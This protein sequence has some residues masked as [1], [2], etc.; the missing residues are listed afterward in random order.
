[1]TAPYILGIDQGTTSTTAQ[2][3][4]FS[5]P[6]R[7]LSISKISVDHPQVYPQA[8]WVS[9]RLGDIWDGV[10]RSVQLT[11]AAANAQDSRF[12]PEKI[13]AIGLTNQRETLCTFERG[14]GR[15]LYDTIVWQCKRSLD[16]CQELRAAQ[17][18]ET[19]RRKTGLLLDPYFTASKMTW[20]LR[21]EP[22]V[23]RMID[24][25][26]ALWGTIDTW[27]LY[28][29]TAGASYATEGSNASR[30]LLHNI[31][32]G[33][34]DD[35]LLSIFGVPHRDCLPEIRDSAGVFG[36][37]N[38]LSFL[39]DGIPIAGIL[40]DQ[41]AALAGQT[42]FLP[43]DAKCTYGTGAFI[44]INS[45]AQYVPPPEGLLATVAWTLQGQRTYA[46]EG[47]TF[48]AGAAVQ[49]IREQ[50][51]L[52][53]D[54]AELDRFSAEAIGSPDIYFVP[55]LSGLGS[56]H[57]VPHARGAIL[58]MTRG[59]TRAELA[60]AALEGIAFSVAELMDVMGKALPVKTTILKV[61][62]GAA[63]NDTLMRIQA[64]LA[65][66]TIDRPQNLETTSAGAALF[67]AHGIGLY[68]SL[69]RMAQARQ[70]DVMIPPGSGM[71]SSVPIQRHKDGWQRAVAAVKTFAGQP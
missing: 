46:L 3:F 51:G 27:L 66:V 20:L 71:S 64:D 5:Q 23:R 30:T 12:K 34:Y 28:R 37:T 10:T 1:M 11:L 22:D 36:Y 4:D 26:Q 38:G 24:A 41:Q 69:S 45:G 50:L 42:C 49:F 68:E 53:A 25:K 60:R 32:T 16:I 33:S 9:H 65:G 62:G 8:G 19:V 47:S 6:D 7:P 13:A 59:T 52:I 14:S 43:G 31:H 15:P 39:P 54:Y 29:L 58:G 40:G 44:L 21:H 67:A 63:R 48:I 57:W 18:E 35:E 2:V 61:D 55:A 70:R 56:P 17:L